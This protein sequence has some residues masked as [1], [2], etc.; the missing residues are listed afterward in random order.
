MLSLQRG[1]VSVHVLA[2]HLHPG[3]HRIGGLLVKFISVCDFVPALVP[4]R[5]RAEDV[6]PGAH[7][8]ACL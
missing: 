4:V 6:V 1:V 5:A 3:V 8:L 2:I 7:L